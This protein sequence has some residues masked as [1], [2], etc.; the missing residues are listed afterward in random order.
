MTTDVFAEPDGTREAILAA[1]YRALC[2][3][4]YSD[5]TIQRIGDEFAKSQSLIYH[6][7]D[8]KDEL[9]LACLEY[10]LERFE[11]A[12]ADDE[13]A[14]PRDRLE[15]FVELV[16]AADL[17]ADSHQFFASLIELRAR[18]CHDDDYE[19]HF[20]RSDRVFENYLADVIETGVDRGAFRDCDPD[21]VATTIV[22]MLAGVMLRRSTTDD[23]TTWLPAL[24]AELA[25][26]LETRVYADGGERR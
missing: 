20:T 7:Y 13:L 11:E 1:T 18:A 6:H 22:T 5:L 25:T 24:R 19:R 16:L 8:S 2:E 17:E 15:A 9:V 21:R 23:E 14:G 4:G 3:H 26:Y 10:M 12:F